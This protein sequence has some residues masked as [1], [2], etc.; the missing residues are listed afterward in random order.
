MWVGRGQAALIRGLEGSAPK[1]RTRFLSHQSPRVLAT[2]RR[3]SSTTNHRESL[4]PVLRYQSRK[5]SPPVS[6]VSP[7]RQSPPVDSKLSDD[8]KASIK[9]KIAPVYREFYN[10]HL[11]TV[12]NNRNLRNVIKFAPEDSFSESFAPFA[13]DSRRQLIER[14]RYLEIRKIGFHIGELSLAEALDNLIEV[15][16]GLGAQL[17]RDVPF[18]AICWSSL[19]PVRRRIV[20]PASLGANFCA[21]V[22]AG[23]LAA[24]VS[25]PLDVVRTRQQ[26]EKDRMR[27][28]LT[29]TT[30]Q[31]LIEIWRDGGLKGGV[32][33][34]VARTGLQSRSCFPF[35]RLSNIYCSTENEK[36]K[37]EVL[38]LKIMPERWNSIIKNKSTSLLV[39]LIGE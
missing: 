38:H 23:S 5:S 8:I 28:L 16:D 39:H 7:H 12:R 27:A 14:P 35:I 25:C 1:S 24:A 19:E 33:P 26:I 34:R 15:M 36:N 30:S 21:G 13:S 18:S 3:E 6:A 20:H 11:T 31:T 22:V 37:T 10:V 29:M 9:R 2:S 4:P 17:A 32:G